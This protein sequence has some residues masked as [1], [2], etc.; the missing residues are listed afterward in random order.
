MQARGQG[1]LAVDATALE[2]R[3]EGE[4]AF[5][6]DEVAEV[7]EAELAELRQALEIFVDDGIVLADG[8]VG[9]DLMVCPTHRLLHWYAPL[10]RR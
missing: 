7:P 1:W 9:S 3:L 4:Q 8:G 10:R 2:R 5:Y 6:E